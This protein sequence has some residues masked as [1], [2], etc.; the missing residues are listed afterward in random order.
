MT[1]ASPGT[2]ITY[3]LI[4][5]HAGAVP[6]IWSG[7]WPALAEVYGHPLPGYER[8]GEAYEWHQ[9]GG[10]AKMDRLLGRNRPMGG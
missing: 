3:D 9:E 5:G 6:V 2:T 10:I 8:R 1:D 4:S 7:V